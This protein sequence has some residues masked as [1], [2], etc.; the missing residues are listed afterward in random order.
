[1]DSLLKMIKQGFR[2]TGITPIPFLP[3]PPIGYLMAIRAVRLHATLEA[4]CSLIFDPIEKKK[5]KKRKKKFEKKKISFSSQYICKIFLTLYL[6][7]KNVK[8]AFAIFFSVFF[9]FS[10]NAEAACGLFFNSHFSPE[11]TQLFFF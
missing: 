6:F 10:K 1:M 2:K 4:A 9:I 5:K 3:K 8:F 7:E 11:N